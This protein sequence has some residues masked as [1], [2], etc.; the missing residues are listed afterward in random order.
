M[1]E[2]G[3]YNEL[4]ILR[5]TSVGLYL[6]D[7]AGEDVLLPN[8]YCPD[9]IEQGDKL[10]VFVYKDHEERKVA[11][12]LT[13]KIL[14][15]DFALLKVTAVS[16]V[17]AFLDWGLE[18]DLMVPFNEQKE[19]MEEG[20][21][22]LVYMNIDKKTDRLY[23]S[24]K[25][26]KFLQNESLT[27]AEGDEVDIIIMQKT[28]LGFSVVVNKEHKGLVFNNEI[29]RT[30]KVGDKLKG[31]VKNIRDDNKID[32]SLQPLG[33]EKFNDPNCELILTKLQR[34]NNY[35]SITDNS[36]PEEIYSSLGISKKAFKK[37]IGSLYKQRKITISSDG[38]T[39]IN[40][41]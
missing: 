1:I 10:R 13:P 39:L 6:G 32:I 21:W 7:G 40:Q 26:D 19:K 8:K 24:N 12:N 41:A 2:I 22:Y 17:G 36:S 27:V 16:P 31:F 33:Y 14:L 4:E 23:G 30:L 28:D 9:N 3:K 29:F 38:I 15:N 34:N 37:A 25:L 20:N 35:L 18:K 11:T 5:H